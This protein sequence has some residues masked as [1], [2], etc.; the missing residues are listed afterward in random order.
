M[1]EAPAATAAR[2][3]CGLVVSIDRRTPS[4]AKRFD[5]RHDAR[6]FGLGVDRVG[7]RASGLATDVEHV[8]AFG[9]QLSTVF[10]RRPRRVR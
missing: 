6:Q 9:G 10:D 8:G 3:T 7:A 1:S 5:H 2:A 4:G